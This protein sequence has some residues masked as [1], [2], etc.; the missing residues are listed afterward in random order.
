MTNGHGENVALQYDLA[1]EQTKLTYPNNSL[2]TRGYDQ[3]G[4]LQTVTDWLGHQTKLIYNPDSNLTATTFPT[5]T[6]NQDKYAYNEAD[7]ISETKISKGSETLA[8]LA[9]ARDNDGQLKK[10][11]SKGLPGEETPNTAT[12]QTIASPKQA[13]TAYEYDA[14]NNP[15][16]TRRQHLHLRRRKRA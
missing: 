10:T 12:T 4:R 7:Q 11:T 2:V 15:D 9:Y 5:S 8:S 13:G 14:A 1:N 16:Q 3:A 6:T